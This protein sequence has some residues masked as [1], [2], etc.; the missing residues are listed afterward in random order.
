[1]ISRK[2]K[3][4]YLFTSLFKRFGGSKNICPYCKTILNGAPVVDRK[5]VVTA[6][7]ECPQCNMLVRVPTDEVAASKQ[8][9]QEAYSQEYTTDCPSDEELQKLIASNFVDSDRDYS[10]YIRFF[11]FLGVPA[12][13]RV[14][15][16]GC[17]WGY[18]LHQF[19]QR[20][21]NAE[22]FEVSVPRGSYGKQKLGL[23]IFSS[24]NDLKGKYDVIFSSHVL[25]HLPDFSEINNLYRDHLSE[26]GLFIAVTPN[27]SHDFLKARYDA[28]HQLWGKVHPVL[29]NKKFVQKNFG[30]ELLYLDSW[31]SMNPEF[32]KDKISPILDKWELVYV[33]NR[34]A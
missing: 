32:R 4:N 21:F 10:R 7:V 12:G 14:L 1:M 17:S 25:E 23:P 13:A 19:R 11:D 22:G 27:G 15:D 30:K 29:L 9:Y 5:Y 3:I 33:L 31:E 6:L 26:N 8:F 2:E 20:G 24:V 16:F 18:G 34:R 28:Y